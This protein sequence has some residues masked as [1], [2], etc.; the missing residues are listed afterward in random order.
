MPT[1]AGTRVQNVSRG[2]DNLPTGTNFGV[3]ATFRCK[4]VGKHAPD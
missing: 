2:T 1:E 4:V 3:S